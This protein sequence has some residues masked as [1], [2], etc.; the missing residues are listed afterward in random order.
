MNDLSK[1][2]EQYLLEVSVE[3]DSEDICTDSDAD[4]LNVVGET[5]S[6][7]TFAFCTT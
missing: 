6:D 3:Y 4:A 7:Y 5:C 1:L 2:Q